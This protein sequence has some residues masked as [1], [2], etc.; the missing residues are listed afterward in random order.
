MDI[1]WPVSLGIGGG[2]IVA[3]L[4]FLIWFMRQLASGAILTRKQADVEVAA[5]VLRGD[6]WKE[7]ALANGAARDENA[8]LLKKALGSNEIVDQF[9]REYLPKRTSTPELGEPVTQ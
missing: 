7:T 8:E 4:T 6:E 3:L 9:F 2:S 5:A 1:P